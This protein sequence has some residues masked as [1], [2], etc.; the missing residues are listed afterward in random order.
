MVLLPLA[1]FLLVARERRDD[2]KEATS[3]FLS[4]SSFAVY[5]LYVLRDR[6]VNKR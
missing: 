4:P 6:N 3:S 2:F 1:S 5:F